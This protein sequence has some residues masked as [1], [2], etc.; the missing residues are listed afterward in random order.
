[1]VKCMFETTMTRRQK[2]IQPNTVSAEAMPTAA[3]ALPL[4]VPRDPRILNNATGPIDSPTSP[5][6]MTMTRTTK[7]T[8]PVENPIRPQTNVTIASRGLRPSRAELERY[9]FLDDRH[10]SGL[11]LDPPTGSGCWFLR[12]SRMFRWVR[13][14]VGGVVGAAGR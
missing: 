13:V 14:P 8:V 10:R 5:M 7:S 12:L 6:P 4:L 1:M 9:F 11:N 2:P 3:N